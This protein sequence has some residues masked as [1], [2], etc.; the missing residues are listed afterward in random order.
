MG[1]FRCCLAAALVVVCLSRMGGTEP[2]ESNHEDERRADDTSG[3]DCVDTNED[4][5]NWAS[6]GQ[7]EANP[8][9]MREN[10]RK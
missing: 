7:C 5:V 4:C 10:C 8:S 2:L 9:Y 6:T 3:D 1:V